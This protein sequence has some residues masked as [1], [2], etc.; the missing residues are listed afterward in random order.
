MPL[1][2]IVRV[3]GA[4]L[5]LGLLV[6]CTPSWQ[7]PIPADQIDFI[8]AGQTSSSAGATV[9]VSVPSQTETKQLFG[10]DLYAARVQ[11]VWI[12]VDNQTT[13][14]LIL[15]RNAIDDA[16]ISPAEAAYLR[17]SGSILT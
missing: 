13:Q 12:K 3:V 2:E 16:Y 4:L 17:H 11:P 10:T 8:S 6:R 14:D 15:L 5:A 1:R 7:Q 9:T